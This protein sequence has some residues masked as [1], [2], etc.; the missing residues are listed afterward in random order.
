MLFVYFLRLPGPDPMSWYDVTT[1]VHALQLYNMH[2]FMCRH[3][4]LRTRTQNLLVFL[5]ILVEY[6][7]DAHPPRT[8]QTTSSYYTRPPNLKTRAQIVHI[9]YCLLVAVAC[10]HVG[11]CCID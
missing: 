9:L 10:M 4:K 2:Y 5:N 11:Y 7:P 6:R 1:V 8:V 3:P